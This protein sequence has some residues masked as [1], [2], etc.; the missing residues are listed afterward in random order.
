MWS[1]G[2]EG[3]VAPPDHAALVFGSLKGNVSMIKERSGL[4]RVFA[5]VTLGI[6]LGGMCAMFD[7]STVSAGESQE[8]VVSVRGLSYSPKALSVETGTTVIWKNDEPLNYPVVNGKHRAVASD[9]SFDT[10]EIAPGQQFAKAFLKPGTFSYKCVIH[11]SIM[12][13]TVEVTGAPIEELK[14]IAVNIV[15]PSTTETETWGFDPSAVTVKAGTTVTWRNN[16]SQNHTV[17]AT[18]GSF[19]SKDLAPGETFVKKFE[20]VSAFRYKCTP[21]PW[22]VGTLSVASA[23][24]EVPLPPPPPEEPH[25]RPVAP[26][27]QQGR[28]AS[29]GPV[30]LDVHMVEPSLTDPKSWGFTP[31]TLNAQ[32]GDTVVW[33]NTGATA[34][35]ATAPDGSFD[36]GD[37]APGAKFEH[38][39]DKTGTFT[40]SCKPHPWMTGKIV[41]AAAGAPR[42]VTEAPGTDTPGAESPTGGEKPETD[43]EHVMA[44]NEGSRNALAWTF[45]GWLLVLNLAFGVMWKA[46]N[47]REAAVASIAPDD[48]MVSRSESRELVGIGV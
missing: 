1:S 35:T 32:A 37:V 10:G 27:V 19:D 26:P 23:S 11:P 15:E 33:T 21:H 22:M 40:F 5:A 16:G 34:H 46:R 12:D 44:T 18:D 24:G 4:Q 45:G 39:L 25:A 13:G 47:P 28:G 42:P 48:L 30:K 17:T 41:V 29:G 6:V 7:A 31:K 38:K 14:D 9:G 20:A 43:G 3:N 8:V 36:S 2:D